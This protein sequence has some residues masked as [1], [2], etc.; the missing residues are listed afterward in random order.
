MR[1]KSSSKPTPNQQEYARQIKRLK[2]IISRGE[3][4][5]YMFDKSI[6]TDKPKRI[7]KSLLNKLAGLKSKDLYEK[8][9]WVDTETGEIEPAL[10]RK[11][12]IRKE[13]AKK[14]HETRKRNKRKNKK[15][16]QEQGENYYP[17][18]GGIVFSNI[19]ENFIS[20]LSEPEPNFVPFNKRTAYDL[21]RAIEEQKRAKTTLLSLTYQMLNEI[22]K[23]NL[24]WRL[25]ERADEVNELTTY[26]LYGSTSEGVAS[27]CRE[28]AEIIKG[29]PLTFSELQDLSE[30]EEYNESHEFPL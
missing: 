8:A 21:Q 6:V 3:K 11:K 5:G 26:I 23:D 7:T 14:G 1:K 27:A 10:D 15:P 13:A 17:N 25:N 19:V 18:G 28:L 2:G 12:T 30:Q 20:K 16:E 4:Q 9:I 29:E 22:G 24:G